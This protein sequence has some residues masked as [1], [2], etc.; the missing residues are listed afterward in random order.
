MYRFLAYEAEIYLPPIATVTIWHC[1]DLASGK[2]KPIKCSDVKD[3]SLPHFEGLTVDA[4]LHHAKNWP[5]VG[6][7]LPI[8]PREVEKMPRSYLANV[9]Y[10]IVGKPFRDWVDQAIKTRNEKIVAE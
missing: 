4:M 6:M 7:A 10:T 9:I 5:A 2:R 8:E 1:R 3:I